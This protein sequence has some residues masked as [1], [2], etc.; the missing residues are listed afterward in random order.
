M[1][2]EYCKH[3]APYFPHP[4]DLTFNHYVCNPCITRYLKYSENMKYELCDKCW[5]INKVEK[6]REETNPYG[7][8]YTCKGCES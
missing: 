8:F 6:M 2:K 3:K 5:Q 4:L 1:Y 7:T